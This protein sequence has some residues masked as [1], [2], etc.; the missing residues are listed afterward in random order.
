MKELADR[1]LVLS[2]AAK[3]VDAAW[4]APDADSAHVKL[5]PETGWEFNVVDANGE[6]VDGV[7][8]EEDRK[9]TTGG[10][11]PEAVVKEAEKIM[12]VKMRDQVAR[13]TSSLTTAKSILAD[14]EGTE[15]SE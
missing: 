15:E 14:L 10:A 4:M 1:L 11:T 6:L 5:E 12:V 9:H 13:I 8:S 2:R 3:M 7:L